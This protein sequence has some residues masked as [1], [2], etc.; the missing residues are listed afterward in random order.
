MCQWQLAHAI[1]TKWVEESQL[2]NPDNITLDHKLTKN[3]LDK[4]L[5]VAYDNHTKFTQSKVSAINPH[6]FASVVQVEIYGSHV[7]LIL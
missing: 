3:K 6:P 2:L 4:Q 5:L 1:P 7:L